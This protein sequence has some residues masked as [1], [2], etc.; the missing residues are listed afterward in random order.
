M[1]RPCWRKETVKM[2]FV[3]LELGKAGIAELLHHLV[4]A[5]GL[6]A[7]NLSQRTDQG[8]LLQ[9]LEVMLLGHVGNFMAQ[10]AGQLSLA[11]EAAIQALGHKNITTRRSEGVD[12]FRVEHTEPP[13][14]ILAPAVLGNPSTD[15]VDVALQLVV[16]HQGHRTQEVARDLPADAVFLFNRI[17]AKQREAELGRVDLLLGWRRRR[18]L[19]W[20]G[21]GRR[22]WRLLRGFVLVEF[23]VEPLLQQLA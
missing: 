5:L 6:L 14:D 20:R 9:H 19:G 2:R 23:L 10:H 11:I 12:R 13:G 8:R 3:N 22:G 4:A 1:E 15:Q 7:G 17:I 21:R 16:T 18:A